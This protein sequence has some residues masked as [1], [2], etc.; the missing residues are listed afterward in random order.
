MRL[1]FALIYIFKNKWVSL[2]ENLIYVACQQQRL[3]QTSLQEVIKFFLASRN[4]C[5]LLITFANSLD[6]DQD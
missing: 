1:I 4:F 3:S 5:H 2:Q 6:P